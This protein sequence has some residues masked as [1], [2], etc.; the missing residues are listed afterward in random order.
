MGTEWRNAEDVE[1]RLRDQQAFVG[2]ICDRVET[3]TARCWVLT[4]NH[5]DPANERIER[6]ATITGLDDYTGTDAICAGLIEKG[7]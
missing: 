1:C 6:N 4:C 2:A 3:I 7:D 5:Y